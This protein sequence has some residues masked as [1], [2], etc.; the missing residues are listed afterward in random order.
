MK[1]LPDNLKTDVIIFEVVGQPA[2]QGSMR[3]FV[4]RPGARPIVVPDKPKKLQ[5]WRQLVA[6]QARQVYRG[7]LLTEAVAV[8]LAFGLV[9]PQG[10]YGTG[11]NASVLKKSAPPFPI[12]RTSKDVDKLA[13]GVLDALSKVLWQDDCQVQSLCVSKQWHPFA[14][15]VVEVA[16]MIETKET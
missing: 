15:L 1:G 5:Y 13:R 16:P 12:N 6:H 11:R 9:R 4:P 10:H 2:T 8:T 14:R 3:A 7:P